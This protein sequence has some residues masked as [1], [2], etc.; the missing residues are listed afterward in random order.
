MCF[1]TKHLLSSEQA[2]SF[3]LFFFVAV[4][5]WEQ[6]LQSQRK[7][8]DNFKNILQKMNIMLDRKHVKCIISAAF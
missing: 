7:A 2:S 5:F 4:A 1:H 8:P 6:L 3:F